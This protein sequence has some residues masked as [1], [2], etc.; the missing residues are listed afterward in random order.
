MS[1]QK[2]CF[3]NPD[4]LTCIDLTPTNSSRS[5]PATCTVETGLSDFHKLIVTILK[6]P[7]PKQKPNI[8]TFRDYKRFKN[9]LFRL[10]HDYEL[11][12]LDVCNLEFEH[13]FNIFNKVL[14]K[15]A[16]MKKKPG[17]IATSSLEQFLS[18]SYSEKMRWGRS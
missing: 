1:K 15:H 8:Q 16:S 18:S 7:F 6:L 5:F 11:S 4:R 3:K 12:K 14:N 9:D 2:T 10:E 13:F 17:R